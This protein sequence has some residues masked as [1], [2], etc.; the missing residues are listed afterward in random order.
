MDKRRI[1][2]SHGVEFT[3]ERGDEIYGT[4]PFTSKAEK[5]YV[6]T[7][8]WLWDSKT[9]GIGGNVSQFLAEIHKTYRKRLTSD[10]ANA[11]AHDRGLPV[12]A[13]K[14]WHLGW[15]GWAYAIPYMDPSGT[16][17]DIR[18]WK[19]GGRTISTAGIEVGLFGAHHLNRDM[20]V[21]VYVC[22]GE[23]DTIAW[24]EALTQAKEPGIVVGVPGAGVFKQEWSSWFAGR[25]VH[26]LYDNDGAGEH[27]EILIEKRLKNTVQNITFLHWPSG[28][29][30]GFDI[31]DWVV[32]WVVKDKKP[33]ACVSVLK[34]LFQT[35]TRTLGPLDRAKKEWDAAHPPGSFPEPGPTP[36]PRTFHDPKSNWATTVPTIQD[37]NEI[38]R[39]WLYLDST[40][41]IEVML[42]T[43]I[44][45]SITGPPIWMFLVSP[46]GG[47][48]TE[49]L[50]ALSLCPDV[51][52][53][54]TLTP[55]S[56]ISGANIKD[57]VDPSL[58]PRL[59]GR[60]MVIKDFTSILSM[61]D[62]DKDEIFGIL[63]DAYDGKCGKVFGNGVTR[64]YA[65]R[66]SI[67]AAVT[68]RI[69]DL[70][71]Q[72]AQL[73]ERFMKLMMGDNLNHASEEAIITRAISNINKE[74]A[75]QFELQDVVRAFVF[76]R[77]TH[78]HL[79]HLSEGITNRIV[80]LGMF[81]ARMRGTVSRDN[82]HN[83]IITSR[84]SAEI[85]SRLGIQLAKLGQSLAIVYGHSR[86]GESEY[87]VLKKVMLDTVP[88]RTEDII[89]YMIRHHPSMSQ[90]ISTVDLATVSR[91]PQATVSRLLQD[92]N[93]L[94]IVQR[95]GAD[96]SYRHTWSLTSYIKNTILGAGLYKTDDELR[97]RST[98]KGTMRI[99]K[100]NGSGLTPAIR[101]SAGGQTPAIHPS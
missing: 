6:N 59:N 77:S 14:D 16:I 39:K 57:G 33:K 73:G 58:I 62:A 25:R 71:G 49:T 97:T 60:I 53:T 89:R 17:V 34:K 94:D 8:T 56:L 4:C 31:R 61:R 40:V 26:T 98:S 76:D 74:T 70:A 65:S 72:H 37:V 101:G 9:A 36:A 81:G 12:S 67:L 66:F 80:Q 23:W 100:V 79:P 42:A 75:M 7:K 46:P 19:I 90:P 1:F 50:N 92:L 29:P 78:Q 43:I 45:Q 87:T 48:K 93:V 51:Y 85:G 21:P 84:P 10:R 99:R 52:A 68:P 11:L 28:L 35:N 18:T 32:K 91:Y 2:E 69:Y 20:A 27:G 44:S 82:Y 96:G 88:Q 5:F 41:A 3:G 55:P 83:D 64:A 86:V 63:R 38:F 95:H 22:E 30:V 47:A 24:A 15:T 13:F 54:S